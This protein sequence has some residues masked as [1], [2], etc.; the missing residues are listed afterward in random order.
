MTS[1]HPI[2]LINL[3]KEYGDFVAVDDLSLNI[4]KNS[5]TGLLG[6]NGA[7]KSTSLKILTNLIAP[8]SGEALLNGISVTKNP[9]EALLTV[10]TVIETPEFYLYL[11]PR[12]TFRYVGQL[13][14]MRSESIKYETDVLLEKVKMSEWADKKLGTFSKGMRQRIALAQALLNSPNII[15]LDEPTSGLDPRGMAEMREILKNLRSGS[16]DLTVL[17]SSHMLHEVSDLCDYIAMVNHGKLLVYD[18]I[19]TIIGDTGTRRLILKTIEKPT[20]T[21]L[22]T[23]SNLDNV[24]SAELSGTEIELILK[25]GKSEQME[26]FNT[27]GTMG[28]TVY[29][30]AD[31]ANALEDKYLSLIK[32]SR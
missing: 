27:L 11:T 23:L 2:E 7:G 22:S 26:L 19:D 29:S 15:I 28:L 20:D 17:M 21:I 13:L 31:D 12:E 8:T 10:G 4:K 6:P 1:E 24:L 18:D 9:W 25:G 3:H 30:L 5:F 14:G 32:E 16:K